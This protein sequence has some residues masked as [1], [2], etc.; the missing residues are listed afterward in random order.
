MTDAMQTI[1]DGLKDLIFEWEQED[2]YPDAPNN[3]IHGIARLIRKR[4]IHRLREILALDSLVGATSE[5]A[6][7]IVSAIRSADPEWRDFDMDDKQSAALIQ[8]RDERILRECADKAIKWRQRCYG[9]ELAID[10][11]YA[12]RDKA[13][14]K[15][16]Q[17]AILTPEATNG[18]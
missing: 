12:L 5:E 6:R 1:R 13:A 3:S 14:D 7:K 15:S 2:P 11:D 18:Q 8:A 9:R 10:G 4:H 16:I 17:D